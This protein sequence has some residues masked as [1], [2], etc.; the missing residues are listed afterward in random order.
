[1]NIIRQKTDHRAFQERLAA[2]SVALDADLIKLV[3]SII[4]DVRVRGD[5]ALIDYTA[6]FDN[7]DLKQ[8]DLRVTE[9]ELRRSAE[10]VDE[11]VLVALREAITNVRTIHQRQLEESWT[12]SPRDGVQLGQH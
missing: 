3:T 1:M 4:D 10:G 6:K 5:E 11:R 7:V 8:T 12:I 2:R 9:E